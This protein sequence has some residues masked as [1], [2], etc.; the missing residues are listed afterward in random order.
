M[1][2]TFSETVVKAYNTIA[3]DFSRTRYKSWDATKEFV[4]NL[5]P[6]YKVCEGGCGN[7]RNFI[8]GDIEWHG[9]DVSEG[10][11]EICHER[12]FENVKVCNGMDTGYED[13]TFDAI[14]SIA[15]IHHLLSYE[16]RLKFL[17]EMIRITKSCS[18][19]NINN[20]TF[21]VWATTSKKYEQSAN[22]DQGIDEYSHN[23]RFVKYTSRDDDIEIVDR[24][25]HFYSD[26]EF[27]RMISECPIEG[28]V[29]LIMNNY[30]FTGRINK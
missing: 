2:N 16:D 9:Y 24:F 5:K 17:Q 28:K 3:R 4:N 29:E 8:R 26:N 30:V 23:D 21:Q 20:I 6:G 11:V 10:L 7:G 12:G 19:E 25:Y 15:V 14:M 1:N 27:K 22:A 18:D 13:N